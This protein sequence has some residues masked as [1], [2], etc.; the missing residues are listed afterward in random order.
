[1]SLETTSVQ[2]YLYHT[3]LHIHETDE[4]GFIANIL[5]ESENAANQ[6][7]LLFLHCFLP[8]KN[9]CNSHLMNFSYKN[10]FK[11]NKSKIWWIQIEI[12]C[13][14]IHF[15]SFYKHLSI[16]VNPFPKN[17]FRTLPN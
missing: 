17:K 13:N 9:I 6:R 15:K 7:L 11:V 3:I 2:S 16:T 12:N 10:A 4:K 1:M 14:T 5:E 8:F